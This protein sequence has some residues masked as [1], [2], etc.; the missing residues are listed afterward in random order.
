M[1][2]NNTQ[3]DQYQSSEQVQP[4]LNHGAHEIFDVQE[5]LKSL[6]AAQNQFT[7]WK[8]QIKDGQLKQVVEKQHAYL[9]DVYN[10]LLDSFQ[11]GNAPNQVT[12][13]YE[14]KLVHDFTFGLRQQTPLAPIEAPTAVN[15][16]LIS[17]ILLGSVKTCAT[18]CTTAALECTNPVVRRVVADSVPNLIEL[19]YELSIYQNQHHIYQVPLL[20]EADSSM[21]IQ[22]FQP[23]S[24]IGLSMN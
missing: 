1:L 8:S 9:I 3:Q 6:I 5:T 21:I 22:N 16:A 19:G 14:M 13:P 20:K 17:G 4:T 10:T 2:K 11:T 12:Y 7:Y 24:K 15:D 18:H 23:A